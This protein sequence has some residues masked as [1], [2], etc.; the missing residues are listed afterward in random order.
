VESCARS[1]TSD[2]TPPPREVSGGERQ[3]KQASGFELLVKRISGKRENEKE[4]K[5]EEWKNRCRSK[6]G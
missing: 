2:C 1:E 5:E 4:N 6:R 3:P